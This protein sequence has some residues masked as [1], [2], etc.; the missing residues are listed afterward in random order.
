MRHS[1][2]VWSG[3][4]PIAC[5]A[6]RT[7]PPEATVGTGGRPW[8]WPLWE[9]LTVLDHSSEGAGTSPLRSR[10]GRVPDPTSR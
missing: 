4:R 1:G 5:C 10:H 8:R 2:G 6:S 7:G 3:P 9:A